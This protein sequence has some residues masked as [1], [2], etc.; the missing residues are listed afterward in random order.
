MAISLSLGVL[1]LWALLFRIREVVGDFRK[2]R[3]AGRARPSERQKF[4]LTTRIESL[5]LSLLFMDAR[6]KA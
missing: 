2:Q 3:G 4:C 1:F 5:N 6:D